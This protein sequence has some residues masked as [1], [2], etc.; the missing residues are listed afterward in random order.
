MTDK[1]KFDEREENERK[2]LEKLSY[3]NI[4]FSKFIYLFLLLSFFDKRLH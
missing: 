3:K 4:G 2:R 1:N